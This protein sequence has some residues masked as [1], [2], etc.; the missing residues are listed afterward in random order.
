MHSAKWLLK[1]FQATVINDI[2]LPTL[3]FTLVALSMLF[4]LDAIT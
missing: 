1:R 3:F 4:L 2:T